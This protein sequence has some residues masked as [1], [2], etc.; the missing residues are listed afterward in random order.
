MRLRSPPPHLRSRGPASTGPTTHATSRGPT[1]P[2]NQRASTRCLQSNRRQPTSV[3]QAC[4]RP[5]AVLCGPH[6]SQASSEPLA[7]VH[8]PLLRSCRQ[9]RPGACQ[10]SGAESK[11]CQTRRAQIALSQRWRRQPEPRPMA[12]RRHGQ[13]APRTARS[14]PWATSAPCAVQ[15]VLP[16]VGNDSTDGSNNDTEDSPA[17]TRRQTPIPCVAFVGRDTKWHTATRAPDV[18]PDF[19]SV[20][21][22]GWTGIALALWLRTHR[23]RTPLMRV[24]DIPEQRRPHFLAPTPEL[25]ARRA[26][27]SATEGLG[28]SP[29]GG[30][31]PCRAARKR[32]GS[33]R[34]LTGRVAL[35][36][37]PRCTPRWRAQGSPRR[38]SSAAP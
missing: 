33:D 2:T 19:V 1:L 9:A 21:G 14:L 20:L 16:P 6:A 28:R 3:P 10:S 4:C 34:A 29:L 15:R 35:P 13:G 5:C 30:K 26:P 7:D 18:R 38:R 37:A 25:L 11:A 17:N 12:N 22:D 32:E 27:A 31:T 8:Q 36:S 24:P 23:P